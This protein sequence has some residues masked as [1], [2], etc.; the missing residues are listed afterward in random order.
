[1]VYFT[2]LLGEI[3]ICGLPLPNL[4]NNLIQQLSA[5][6]NIK[7]GTMTSSAADTPGNNNNSNNSNTSNNT[8]TTTTTILPNKML[9]DLLKD[10][11]SPKHDKESIAVAL[12]L[13]AHLISRI[14]RYLEVSD[15]IVFQPICSHL[16]FIMIIQIPLAYL[17]FPMG[18]RSLIVDGIKYQ[19]AQM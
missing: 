10:P 3:T 7:T 12:G 18:S 6:D 11:Y 1:M 8:N 16:L 4:D 9:K 2:I 5:L 14:S 13:V 15:T 19:P 17:I